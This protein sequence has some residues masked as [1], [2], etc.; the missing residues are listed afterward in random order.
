L[1]ENFLK[2]NCVNKA[3]LNTGGKIVGEESFT[4]LEVQKPISAEDD[5]V[6]EPK[7]KRGWLTPLMLG[8]G[9]GIIIALGGIRIFSQR[10]VVPN[11]PAATTS[12]AP[13]MTVTVAQASTSL[14]SRTLPVT[15]TIAARDLTPVLPQ[16]NGL[17]VKQILVNIGDNVKAGQVMAVLDNSI[18]QDQIRQARA[19][20]ESKQA[21]VSSKQAD[22]I[23]KQAEV[24][25]AQAAVASAQAVV[26][27]RQAER[28]T[29]QA[30]LTDAQRNFGR[31]QELLQAGA[32]SRQVLET[33][34]TNLATAREAVLQAE[35]NIR[36][37]Q[38][39]VNT[40]Q[41]NV[42]SAQAAVRIASAGTNSAQASVRSNNARVEQ[43]K[44]QLGQ[45]VVR[46][47]VSGYVAEKLV[48]IGDVTGVPPQTQSSTGV[49]GSQKLFSIIQD[50]KL[51][52][53]AQ[54]PQVQL[55]QVR[56]GANVQI[57]SDRDSRIR[58][59]GTVREIEPVVNQE[60][61]EATVRIDLPPTNLLKPGM[62]ASAAITTS[63]SIGV[64][65]PQRAVQPQ[66]DGSAI[67]FMLM[68]EDKVKAQKVQVGEILNNNRIEI[69]NGLQIGDKVVIDGAGYI[70]D[71]D[72][73]RVA[74][75]S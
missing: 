63:S 38:A 52:L 68:G 40:A 51:E 70:K 16:A 18:L 20:V 28:S 25:A 22:V 46:A 48:R 64:A 44:T 59:R 42:G 2:Q 72:T 10:P 53:Q 55:S 75:D 24:E 65:V 43:L 27:Q 74:N 71:G 30:R 35:A 66:P 23:S 61:R 7:P 41:A 58:L 54:V 17:Q 49:G 34:E 12:V 5:W 15:G 6:E 9:M 26:Q 21:D 36:N 29:A 67:V 37:A 45:S 4:E 50:G 13:S 73:V 3:W 57:T 32:I 8:L 69:K 33:A 60:R 11:K 31:N 14:I 1:F 47:P 19:D 39:N 62:F 56:V